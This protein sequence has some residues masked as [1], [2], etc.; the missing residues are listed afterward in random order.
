MVVEAIFWFHPLV[1]WLGSR[2]I[3][4]RERACDEEVLRQGSEPQ[5]YAEGI[6]NV[7]KHYLESPLPCASGVTGSDLKKRI[8]AIMTNPILEGLTF[9]RKVLLAV[10]ATTAVAGP[11]LI[12]ILHV[13]PSRAQ[14]QNGGSVLTFE[15]ASVK[16]AD[17]NSENTSIRM[18]PGGGMNIENGSLKQIIGFAYDVRE[19]Q[20][21][22]GPGWLGSERYDI[23][24]KSPSPDAPVDMRQ[25]TDEQRR[26][27]LEQIRQRMRALLEERFQLAVHRDSKELPVYALVVGKNG[28]KLKE[29][30]LEASRQ[31]LRITRG[32]MN[33]DGSTTELFAKT[34]ANVVGRPVLDRTGLKGRYDFKLEWTPDPGGPMARIGPGEGPAGGNPPD[35][36]GPSIFTAVQE[37]LGLKLE[38]TRGPA[39]IIVIDRVEKASEN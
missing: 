22:G 39:E 5:V 13:P 28:H 20:I 35:L 7:C 24:A 31:G 26:L 1:W 9:S 11:V 4:E 33:A 32:Q 14:S 21:S 15:V 36:S 18:I 19:F 38:S 34:L 12:G 2:L 6:L 23:L 30:Q 8:E 37:Q 25:M 17:P 27:F 10:A 29:S 16:R 3:D